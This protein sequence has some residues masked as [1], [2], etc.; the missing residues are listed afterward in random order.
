MSSGSS[1]MA[2]RS[3]EAR[4]APALRVER[5]PMLAASCTRTEWY[6]WS[7]PTSRARH[8]P[9]RSTVTLCDVILCD[10]CS[11]CSSEAAPAAPPAAV[12]REPCPRPAAQNTLSSRGV[13]ST[14]GRSPPP[15]SPAEGWCSTERAAP[16]QTAMAWGAR[17]RICRESNGATPSAPD[18]GTNIREGVDRGTYE[19]GAAAV[20][21]GPHGYSRART[22]RPPAHGV[23]TL[24][25]SHLIVIGIKALIVNVRTRGCCSARE[26][27]PPLAPSRSNSH[28]RVRSGYSR[29]N[30]GL[31]AP[32][33]SKMGTAHDISEPIPCLATTSAPKPAAAFL[34]QTRPTSENS[35]IVMPARQADEATRPASMAA[36]AAGLFLAP[37]ASSPQAVRPEPTSSPSGAPSRTSAALV[38][39]S[40]P[41]ARGVTIPRAT[42]VMVSNE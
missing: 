14:S 33:P 22:T 24:G 34:P 4:S 9:I 1:A 25:E 13:E 3:F 10:C 30:L 29:G 17:R 12:S 20:T 6:A 21:C 18:R 5:L 38:S 35:A 26:R 28:S 2:M 40:R 23:Y 41:H 7:V 19:G 42:G 15:P 27:S 36:A 39:H 37:S 32:S 31:S 8:R 11:D 16:E